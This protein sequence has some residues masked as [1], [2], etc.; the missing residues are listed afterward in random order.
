MRIFALSDIHVDFELNMHWLG[1]LSSCDYINDTL[2]LAGDVCDEIDRLQKAL[3]ILRAKFANIF[4]VPGNHDLWLRR[5]EC[6]DSIEK[7]RLILELCREIDIKTVPEKI[8][9]SNSNNGVWII[10][11]F[12]W[13][14]K[15]EDGRGSL[16]IQKPG[17]D[18][19]L[20]MWSDNHYIKWPVL[21]D[22][23]TIADYF[24]K[25]NEK[26]IH[27]KYDLP[28]ITFSHFLPREEMMFSEDRKKDLVR[29]A[30]FDRNPSFNFSRVAGCSKIDE[31]I[32]QLGSTIHIYGHQHRNKDRLID[33]VRY[34]SHCL[35]YPHE[36]Q[37]GRI[38]GI[39]Q[40]VK[41]IWDTSKDFPFQDEFEESY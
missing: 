37:T 11:L 20:P 5:K 17:E 9:E 33:N 16:F 35:G 41:L 4:F 2:I 24:L 40:G 26:Y 21:N 6:N 29:L 30:K 28:V 14:M 10:P 36:R 22:Y 31:Q 13:Y 18:P 3:S 32:R 15:P 38:Y 19:S 7:F 12:S 25:M 39:E 27:K 8:T 34:I 1:K 23:K